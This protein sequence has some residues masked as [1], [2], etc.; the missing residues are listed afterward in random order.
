MNNSIFYKQKLDCSV[1]LIGKANMP[2]IN[3]P[4]SLI[5]VLRSVLTG[6]YKKQNVDDL[7]PRRVTNPR[8]HFP[9]RP[10]IN[11]YNHFS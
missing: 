10:D 11:N 8:P 3:F 7:Y 9:D 1:S 6:C 5:N 4:E 2:K